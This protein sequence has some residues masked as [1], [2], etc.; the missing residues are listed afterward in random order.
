MEEKFYQG[1]FVWGPDLTPNDVAA[2]M[3][4]F[5]RD[6]PVPLL[7]DEYIDAFAQVEGENLVVC[8]HF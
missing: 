8:N 3:Q 5:L 6:L 1:T 7:T 4:Q 2:L